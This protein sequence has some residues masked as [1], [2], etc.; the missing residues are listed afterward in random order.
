MSIQRPLASPRMMASPLASSELVEGF[1]I[2]SAGQKSLP[3]LLTRP[4]WREM[5]RRIRSE[6]S[7]LQK[8]PITVHPV[9]AARRRACLSATLLQLY[10]SI[11]SGHSFPLYSVRI[12]LTDPGPTKTDLVLLLALVHENPNFG[13]NV[14]LTIST[15]SP[16][17]VITSCGVLVTVRFVMSSAKMVDDAS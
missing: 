6:H 15:L 8:R 4:C 10:V 14:F 11:P 2:R 17:F 1:A 3:P 5:M 13:G 9:C 16:T 12:D 7:A